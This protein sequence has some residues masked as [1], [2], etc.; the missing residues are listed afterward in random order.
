M[1]KIA[2]WISVFAVGQC[3]PDNLSEF[4]TQNTCKDGSRELSPRLSLDLHTHRG[5]CTPPNNNEEK[6]KPVELLKADTL[7]TEKF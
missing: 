3:S 2:R 7:L 1:G 6:I 4:D 5:M